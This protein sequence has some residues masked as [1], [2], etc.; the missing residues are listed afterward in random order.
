MSEQEKKG[1]MAKHPRWP[2][3]FGLVLV[4]A[5]P[6]L[7]LFVKDSPAGWAAMF[8]GLIFMAASRFEDI[9]EIALASF[10]MKLFERRVDE[11]EGS[12]RDIR[13]LAKESSRL[14]LA[15]IQFAGRMGGFTDDFKRKVLQDTQRLLRVRPESS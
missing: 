14:A 4:I 8:A 9:Q 13:R 3:G 2:I 5:G 1:W 12:V 15:S 11:V 10:S 6:L 7:L